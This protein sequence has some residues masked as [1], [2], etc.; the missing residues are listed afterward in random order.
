[1][2]GEGIPEDAAKAR[3]R[4]YKAALVAFRRVLTLMGMTLPERM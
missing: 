4:F 1:V 3:L 2:F